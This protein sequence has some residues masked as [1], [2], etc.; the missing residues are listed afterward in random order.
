MN[1]RKGAAGLLDLIAVVCGRLAD[2]LDPPRPPVRPQ[3]AAASRARHPSTG[4][5]PQTILGTMPGRATRRLA[6]VVPF[7]RPEE[8]E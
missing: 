2:R 3:E 4:D 7:R 1:A 6:E 8:P 5:R